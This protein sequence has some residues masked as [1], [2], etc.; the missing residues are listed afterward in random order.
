VRVVVDGEVAGEGDAVDCR[1]MPVRARELAIAVRAA[2]PPGCDTASDVTVTCRPPSGVHE[3][4]GVVAPESVKGLSV[5][6]AVAAAS[7]SRG[8][9]PDVHDELA[10]ARRELAAV[11]VPDVDLAGARER[12]ATARE[13]LEAVRAD[14]AAARGAV[15]AREQLESNDDVSVDAA[16]ARER[17]QAA[18]ADASERETE[19]FAAEQAL[20]RARSRAQDARDARERRLQLADRVGTLERRARASLVDALD[21]EYRN[22]LATVRRALESDGRPQRA[23]KHP[24]RSAATTADHDDDRSSSV[25]TAVHADADTPSGGDDVADSPSGVDDDADTPSGGEDVADAHVD[26]V[27]A[28]LA[29]ARIAS[30]DAPV[31]LAAGRFD[32][33]S[34]A[35]AL[36]DAPV[37]LATPLERSLEGDGVLTASSE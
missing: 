8:V 3:Y 32:D 27:V 14:V 2:G 21:G 22:A 11:E 23:R 35:R 33:A 37:V 28:A 29:I 25:D 34:R 9:V 30:L 4:V 7:R 1:S 19:L 5:R 13:A 6:A 31:V 15:E 18:I 36:L 26:D 16:A 24:R 12:V 17:L 20:D 10:A